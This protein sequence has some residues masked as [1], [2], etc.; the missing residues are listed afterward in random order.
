MREK[1]QKTALRVSGVSII[2]NLLLSAFKFIAGIF[3]HSAAMISDAVHSASDVFSTVIVIIGVKLSGKAADKDHP[4]GH[5]RF[6][7][8]ASLI[9]AFI[10]CATGLGIGL[11]GVQKIYTGEYGEAAFPGMIALAAALIS[12]AVKEGLFQ[13]TKRT[14][15]RIHSSALQADAWH[16]RSD[17]LSSIGSFAGIVGA[18]L[19]FPVCD[20]LASILISVFIVKT[21]LDIFRSASG[22]LTDKSCSGDVEEEIREVVLEQEGVKGLDLLHTRKFGSRVYVDIEISADGDMPLRDAHAIA[23]KVHHAVEDRFGAV[24]HCMVHVNP[25]EA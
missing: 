23:E 22:D 25:A 17:A 20:A 5:E 19:G 7:D 9:L 14:A 16:H 21:A 4:Y 15:D 3:G 10:L 24:K 13:Y 6:E 8:I 1:K 12:I 11:S 18:R 2:A